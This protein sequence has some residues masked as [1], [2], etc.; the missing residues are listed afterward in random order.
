MMKNANYDEESD[1]NYEE[2]SNKESDN[3]YE[4]ESNKESY[5][6]YDKES[7][8]ESYEESDEKSEDEK[9]E[10]EKSEEEYEDELNYKKQIL[11]SFY[12]YLEVVIKSIDDKKHNKKIIN[13][14]Y[15]IIDKYYKNNYNK[16]SQITFKKKENNIFESFINKTIDINKR[17]IKA[18][19]NTNSILILNNFITKTLIY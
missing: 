1:N 9:S 3:N 7:Y 17:L 2:E 10:D 19:D 15:Y 8:E 12:N 18:E 11:K 5:D 4:E 16:E 13:K 14:L 6:E